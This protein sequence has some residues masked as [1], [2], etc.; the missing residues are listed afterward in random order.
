[1]KLLI[2]G[3]RV[4]DPASEQ[5]FVGD[6]LVED[7]KISRIAPRI[8][9]STP[10]RQTIDAK[11]KIVSPGFIDLHVH[12]REPGREDE[13]TIASGGRAAVHGGFT[14]IACMPNTEPV[15]D[16][17]AVC[18]FILSQARKYADCRVL[19]IAA[20]SKGQRGKSLAELGELKESGAVGFSDDGHPVMNADLMRRAMEYSRMLGLPI[21]THCEELSLVQDGVMHEGPVSTRLGFKPIPAEAETIMV[22]R[23]IALAELTGARLHI[24]HVSAAGSVELIRRAKDKGTKISAEVAPHHFSLSD[25]AVG[26]FDTNTK[27]N[28]P[29]RTQKDIAA[30]I[31]GLRDETIDAIASDHAPHNLAEKELEYTL[32]PFG[33][34][35]LETSLALIISKLVNP[36]H[37]SLIKTLAK[38][39]INPAKI[40][41][42]PSGR[43]EAGA[44]ADITIFDPKE[45]FVVDSDYFYSKSKNSP[46]IGWK[47]SGK[48]LNTIVGGKIVFSAKS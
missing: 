40:L 11:G 3:G 26:S 45:E 16:N 27:V 14:C 21:I 24:A 23:D 15:N 46:F 22:A 38:L 25:E 34:I 42:L 28:P 18:N 8:N 41:D 13:E 39:T 43:L 37:V 29:L 1:M 19:P 31:A 10:A 12:L 17:Q 9:L 20:L 32:A 30:L 6:I 7:D 48:V 5:D 36:G 33:M 4:I 2:K 35:G 44:P 47:L